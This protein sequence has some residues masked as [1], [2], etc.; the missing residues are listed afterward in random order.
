MSNTNSKFKVKGD[1][2]G[3]SDLTVSGNIYY[4]GD[5]I[6][7]KESGNDIFLLY[8]KSKFTG[9]RKIIMKWLGFV[10]VG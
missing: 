1:I 9:L 5:L 4:G 6:S 3:E 8:D 7:E 10:D 2:L